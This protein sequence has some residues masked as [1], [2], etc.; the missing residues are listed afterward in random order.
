MLLSNPSRLTINQHDI[1]LGSTF[2][3]PFDYLVALN[4]LNKTEISRNIEIFI[5]VPSIYPT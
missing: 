1:L 4:A 2:S 3:T 5:V